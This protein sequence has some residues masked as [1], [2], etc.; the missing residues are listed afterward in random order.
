MAR[1]GTKGLWRLTKEQLILQHLT[2]QDS[3]PEDCIRYTRMRKADLIELVRSRRR[4]EQRASRQRCPRGHEPGDPKCD[5]VGCF[6]TIIDP[7]PTPFLETLSTSVASGMNHSWV[8]DE[9]TPVHTGR[10]LAARNENMMKW[11][12]LVNGLYKQFEV[13]ERQVGWWW[14]V[15]YGW[16]LAFTG[17]SIW[18]TWTN[19]APK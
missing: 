2:D 8:Y 11:G 16:W 15:P 1:S 17:W 7:Y 4:A 14:R 5:L 6:I 19:E 13:P 18:R 10:A 3:S 12:A 9:W